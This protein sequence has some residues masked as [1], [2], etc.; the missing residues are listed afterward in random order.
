M[1]KSHTAGGHSATKASSPLGQST[2]DSGI[3]LSAPSPALK[4]GHPQA[5]KAPN[6]CSFNKPGPRILCAGALLKSIQHMETT[7]GFWMGQRRD[8]LVMLQV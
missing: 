8:K 7:W 3:C 5:S 2:R 6:F 1:A 4:Q